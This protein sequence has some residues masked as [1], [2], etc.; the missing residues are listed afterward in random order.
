MDQRASRA[1]RH[2]GAVHSAQTLGITS[3]ASRD[4]VLAGIRRFA[5]VGVT[6]PMRPASRAPV[7]STLAADVTVAFANDLHRAIRR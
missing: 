3:M 5:D 4:H 1:K 6:C 7:G 2:A